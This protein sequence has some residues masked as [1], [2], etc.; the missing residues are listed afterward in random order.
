MSRKL[1]F[2]SW[3]LA[4]WFVAP[5]AWGQAV[6]RGPYLQQLTEGS[7]I[8]HWRTDVA[9]DSVVRYGTDS[10]VLASSQTVAGSRTEH[11]VLVS[12]LAANT[13]YYY[14]IGDS[15]GSLAGGTDYHFHTAPPPGTPAATRFWVLGDSGTADA[16]ARAVRDAFKAYSAATPADFM[17]ML[18]DNAYTDGTDAQYQAAVFDTYPV[19]LR[20]LPLW[21]TLGNHD[22]HS[23]D[24]GTQ[25][26]PYYD[27]FDLPTAGEAGG[28]ASGTEAYYAFDY[29]NI[30]FVV[31]DSYDSDRSPGGPMLQWLEADLAGNDK[32]WLIAFWHHPPYTKGSHD[33]DTEGALIDMRQNALPIL[34]A[35]GVDLVM[36]GHS[37]SYERSYLLD[38]HYGS[39]GTLDPIAEVLDPGDG[40]EFGDGAYEKPDLVA[41]EHA[42]A[43]YAVAGS[44]GKTSGGSLDHP[45]MFISLNLLGSMVV[46]VADKRLD[47]VFIDNNGQVQDEFTLL[48]SSNTPPTAAF[49]SDCTGLQCGFT[50]L[51]GDPDGTVTAWS[52]DFGDGQGSTLQNPSHGYASGGVFT[53]T[54]TVTD[55]QGAQDAAT[56]DVSADAGGGTADH[57]AGAELAGAGTVSGGYADTWADDGVSESVQE[58]ESGGKKNSRYSYLEH[59]WQF[60]IPASAMATLYANAWSGGSIDDA[61]EFAWST[62]NANFSPLFTVASTDPDNLQTGVLPGAPS[63]TV[64]IRVTDT[65]RQPGNRTLDTVYV[66]HLFIR[67]E[68]GTGSPP[69]GPDGLLATVAGYDRIDLTW[70]DHASDESG[71]SIERS[72]EGGPFSEVATTGVDQVSFQDSGLT[73]DTNYTYRVRA[74]NA[75][76]FSAWSNTASATTDSAPPPPSISLTLSG[77]RDK[78][79]HVV[80]LVWAGATATDV[81]IYRDGALLTTTANSG[82]YTDHTGNNGGRTYAYQV[83]EAGSA[84]CS[85]VVL[86]SF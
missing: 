82:S 65:D 83:C 57:V 34:E 86:I 46:D 54:L 63:G 40:R 38:G 25:S 29:G 42:G 35:W 53:V 2:L 13:L 81:D 77:S 70:A 8:V 37:H 67:T 47:A 50:D 7:V 48:K 68:T 21:P 78:G 43:V 9:T 18:G 23:A 31:L 14:S 12:G 84:T 75:S 44:S 15:V 73:G 61:F 32:P 85:A 66:D 62:D 80:D 69:A 6:T 33:S 26:G 49:S 10:A 60:Q 64:Y 30:H 1:R 74:F 59:T 41:A 19:L 56:A 52:W 36:A 58:R 22:G 28:L 17:L 45:A 27:I 72:T 76:G 24:S 39:S 16:N 11:G 55:D 20:Q 71:F 3:V 51:S 79:R 4:A 5:L